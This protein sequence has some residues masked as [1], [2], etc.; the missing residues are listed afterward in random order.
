MEDSFA[1]L[2]KYYNV[3][4]RVIMDVVVC[5]FHELEEGG[6][7]TNVYE[8]A[9]I[10]TEKLQ[11]GILDMVR[12]KSIEDIPEKVVKNLLLRINPSNLDKVCITNQK[13]AKVCADKNFEQEYNEKWGDFYFVDLWKN[14]WSTGEPFVE[15]VDEIGL[16]V[17][18]D[19]FSN[20]EIYF[21]EMSD[22]YTLSL[23]KLGLV[24]RFGDHGLLLI[25]DA[26]DIQ[27]DVFIEDLA[28]ND[29]VPPKIINL[30]K[31]VGLYRF[32]KGK[33]AKTIIDEFVAADAEIMKSIE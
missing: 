5:A 17:I 11:T 8:I 21:D 26:D 19:E 23:L 33:T 16:P 31:K 32:W 1:Y 3:P 28:I 29:E 6:V 4:D 22:R 2:E 9:D 10:V 25:D 20:V 15:A 13:V 18:S 27:H 14:K 24:V 30:L 7:D 12:P